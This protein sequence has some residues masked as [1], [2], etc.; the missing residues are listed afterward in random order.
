MIRRTTLAAAGLAAALATGA[1]G[2]VASAATG[3]A[4]GTAPAGP[5]SAAA[6]MEPGAPGTVATTPDGARLERRLA[7]LCDRIPALLARSAERQERLA[8]DA[9]RPGSIA[10][11]EKRIAEAEAAGHGTVA[12]LLKTHLEIRKQVQQ[13]LPQRVGLLEELRRKECAGLAPAPRAT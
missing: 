11:L 6:A 4:P 5:T 7:R 10:R 1:V 2:A 13:V 9:S 12:D 3:S 8:A